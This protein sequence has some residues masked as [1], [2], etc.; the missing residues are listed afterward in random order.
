MEL[1]EDYYELLQ[2]HHRAEN[3]VIEAAY[4]KLAHK[5]HPDLNKSLHAAEYMKKI[6]MAHDILCNA[7]ERRKYDVLWARNTAGT[8]AKNDPPKH[9][10]PDPELVVLPKYIRFKDLGYGDIKTTYF[11]IKN[12]GGPYTHYSIARE[13]LPPWLEITG[14]QTLSNNILPVRVHI[15]AIGQFKGTKYEYFIPIKLENHKTGYDEEIKVRVEMIMKAPV[16]QFD[17][18]TLDFTVVPNTIPQ[19]HIVTLRNTGMCAIEGNL[20]SRQ[21]WIKISPRTVNFTDKQVVQ[22]QIDAAK[23]Y[24]DVYGYIDV[25]T[26]CGEEVLTVHVRISRETA[27]SKKKKPKQE[28]AHTVLHE[29]PECKENAVRLDPYE[30]RYECLQCRSYWPAS[31]LAYS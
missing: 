5:Y 26:N 2:V 12:M 4:K 25:K 30:H 10:D 3:A 29:C 18:K 8:D 6:N 14:I 23:L 16:L 24:T 27:A 9:K 7:A 19:P 17:R 20:S 21:H 13:S 22:V 28:K 15:K 11:D 31:E 1:F